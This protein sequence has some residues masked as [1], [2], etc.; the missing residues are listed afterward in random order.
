MFLICMDG[1]TGSIHLPGLLKKNSLHISFIGLLLY[2]TH[3]VDN[4]NI[5]IIYL[6]NKY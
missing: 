6:S 4:S 2:T 3:Y 1:C 5:M